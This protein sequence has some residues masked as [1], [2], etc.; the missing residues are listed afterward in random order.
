MAAK[1]KLSGNAA[2]GL[3]DLKKRAAKAS[4]ANEASALDGHAESV[5]QSL[6]FETAV[7]DPRPYQHSFTLKRNG[8]EMTYHWNRAGIGVYG[9]YMHHIA[10]SKIALAAPLMMFHRL[11]NPET[12]ERLFTKNVH[13][14]RLQSDGM[15]EIVLEV[16]TEMLKTDN[17]A[18]HFFSSK[19]EQLEGNSEAAAD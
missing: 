19:V 1:K 18:E 13:L 9:T 15:S 16:A 6:T 11:V 5:M 7:V 8:Q 4:A 10:E 3:N 2:Q 17:E 14:E 12:G